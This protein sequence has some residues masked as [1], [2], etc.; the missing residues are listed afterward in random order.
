LLIEARFGLPLSS[1][2]EQ[3]SSGGCEQYRET[4]SPSSSFLNLA[5]NDSSS[6][7]DVAFELEYL[8]L[9]GETCDERPW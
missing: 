4:E 5:K 3:A 9:K 7:L 1:E 8:T 2:A 6:D